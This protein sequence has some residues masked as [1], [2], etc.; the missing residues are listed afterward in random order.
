[1]RTLAL[2]LPPSLKLTMENTICVR[3]F[4]KKFKGQEYSEFIKDILKAQQKIEAGQIEP[5][6]FD[7]K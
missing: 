6:S 1:M 7:E 5:Y 2:T 4:L 3:G